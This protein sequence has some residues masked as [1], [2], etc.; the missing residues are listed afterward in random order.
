VA[1][2]VAMLGDELPQLPLA[3]AAGLIATSK[4]SPVELTLGFIERIR[5]FDPIIRSYLLVT[6]EPALAQARMAEQEITAGRHRGPLH[7]IPCALKDNIETAGIRTTAQSLVLKNYIPA[8]DP[9]GD[10]SSK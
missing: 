10:Q 5:R 1:H 9:A 6:E 8:N 3:E 7:G 2:G 4:I